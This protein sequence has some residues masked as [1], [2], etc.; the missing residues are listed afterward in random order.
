LFGRDIAF[1]FF[2]LP[3]LEFL[4]GLLLTLV[5][6]CLLG[7]ALIYATRAADFFSKLRRFDLGDGPRAHLLSLVAALFLLLAWQAYL[8]IP[9]LLFSTSGP[10]AGASYTDIN[11]TLPL[12][13]VQ[14]G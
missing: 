2:T 7:A 10:I 1:Y 6:V 4:A 11:A 14:I 8:G 9:N 3:A 5:L 12:L 13:Y